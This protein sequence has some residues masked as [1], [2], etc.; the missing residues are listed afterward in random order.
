[1]SLQIRH[2]T[3]ADLALAADLLDATYGLA[4]GRMML[5]ERYLRLQPDGWLLAIK[6]TTPAGMVGAVR[7]DH[8]AY[9][10]MMAVPPAWQRQGI[11]LTMMERLLAELEVHG[12]TTALLDATD[13]GVPLYQRVGFVDRGPTYLFQAANHAPKPDPDPRVRLFQPADLPALIALDARSFGAP[14]DRVL[15]TLL[16]AYADRT[17]ILPDSSGQ[18]AGYVIAQEQTIGPWAARSSADAEALITTA[19]SLPY[20]DQ[21][22]SIVAAASPAAALLA[23]RGFQLQQAVRHM[24]RGPVDRGQTSSELYGQASFVL[25]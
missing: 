12:C 20:F 22:R 19:L 9:V 25:G 21:P 6:D 7:Y 1:M 11:G 16:A 14:R 4:A 5:L 24:G 15:S 2:L 18:L 10:G 13:A 17:W 8:V 23:Q 3:S